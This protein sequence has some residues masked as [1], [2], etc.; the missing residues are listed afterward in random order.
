MGTKKA[1]DLSPE[2][3]LIKNLRRI[4]S[5]WPAKNEAL[6]L[7]KEKIH[8][9]FYKNG[10]PM[11]KTVVRCNACKELHVEDNIDVDHIIPIAGLEGFTDWNSYIPKLFCTVENLQCLCKP[12]HKEKSKAE[13]AQR[14]LSRLKK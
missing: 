1:K 3:W 9:G 14:K 7:A 11:Y 10:N 13:A 8:I 6:K 2:A 4:S 12:C 5:M